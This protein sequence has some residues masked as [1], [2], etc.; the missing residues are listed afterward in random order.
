MDMSL[1]GI[2]VTGASGFVGRNF[3]AI[4]ADKYRLFCLARRSQR[5]AGIPKHDNIRWTQV[6]VGKWDTLRDVVA[7]VKDNGGAD[8]VLHLAAYYDFSNADNPEYER[9]NVKGTRN[10][11][12]L[13][14]QIGTRRFLFTSSL[15]ACEF[16]RRGEALTE[17]SV[18]DANFPYARSKRA[19]EEMMKEYSE[20]FPCTIFRLAAVFSDWCEYPPLYIFLNT[21]LSKRWNARILCGKGES[22]VPYIHV[23]DLIKLFLRV[24]EKSPSLPRLCTYIASPKGCVSQFDLFKTATRYFYGQDTK[25][26]RLP[27]LLAIPGVAL[28]QAFRSMLGYEPVER[29]WMM[30]YIDRKLMTDASWTHRELNWEP[31]SRYGILR[32]LLFVIESMKNHPE[33]WYLR[34]QAAARRVAERPNL[35][36]YQAMAESRDDLIDAIIQ[37]LMAPEHQSRF[38]KYQKMDKELLK[39]YVTLIY[40]L[41]A[42][43]VRTRNRTMMRNYGQTIAY[44]RFVEGFEVK[45]VCDAMNS[46]GEIIAEMLRSRVEMK[47]IEQRL[48]DHI[49]MTFQLAVDEIEDSYELIVARSPEFMEQI[50]K[51]P[52]LVNTTDLERVVHQLEDI[53]QDVLEDRLS[54]EVRRIRS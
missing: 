26:I 45:E 31:T 18:V 32:R 47:D 30:K 53:S 51:V 5:E 4:A 46:I 54:A 23:Q 13:A 42:T 11:L 50:E 41:A 43:T 24:I 34:N 12:K 38:P 37:Y 9:T 2:V 28:R 8:Y 17:E 36:I 10:V 49:T 35:M 14:Q 19:G 52:A 48:Y 44:R 40:E 33:A 16:P 7:G 21:W 29:L 22:A 15:A 20:W 27:K 3:L 1:P 25:P 39:W 6:D